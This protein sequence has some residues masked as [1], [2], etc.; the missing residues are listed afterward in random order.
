MSQGSSIVQTLPFGHCNCLRGIHPPCVIAE[1]PQSRLHILKPSLLHVIAIQV[2][3][4]GG[5]Q[6]EYLPPSL[7]YMC[8]WNCSYVFVPYL[9]IVWNEGE[10]F[11]RNLVDWSESILQGPNQAEDVEGILLKNI[12]LKY[13]KNQLPSRHPCY[14][15]HL[16]SALP[17]VVTSLPSCILVPDAMYSTASDVLHIKSRAL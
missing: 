12:N 8:Q 15:F 9:P 13:V 2:S 1:Q 3:P 7:A 17:R 11:G 5:M 14:P 6:Y 16:T 4:Q 10:N